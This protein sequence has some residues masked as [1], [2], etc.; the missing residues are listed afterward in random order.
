LMRALP[1]WFWT[2]YVRQELSLNDIAK[3]LAEAIE[4]ASHIKPSGPT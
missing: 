1:G 3:A 4:S 2:L